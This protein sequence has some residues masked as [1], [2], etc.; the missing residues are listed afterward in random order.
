MPWW[1]AAGALDRSVRD[2]EHRFLTFDIYLAHSVNQFRRPAEYIPLI[3][4]AM[5]PLYAGRA[6]A[7]GNGAAPHLESAGAIGRLVGHPD[8]PYRSDP[9]PAE[10]LLLSNARCAA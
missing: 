5:A 2:A 10:P 7:S 6:L 3:F 1:Q 9:A 8:R 4:S